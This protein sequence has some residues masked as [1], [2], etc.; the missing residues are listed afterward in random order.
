MKKIFLLLFVFL[1]SCSHNVE[2][3]T[4]YDIKNYNFEVKSGELNKINKKILLDYLINSSD[5]KYNA[6]SNVKVVLSISTR[7][8]SS[9]VSLNN[10]VML[11]N[12]LFITKYDI[13][14]DE[15]VVDNGKIVLSDD[16]EV[17]DNRFANYS[18]DSYVM[19]NFARNLS[20]KLEEK[21]K[22]IEKKFSKCAF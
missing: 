8:N 22:K 12:I 15:K 17:F 1:I 14:I 19:E 20:F 3:L 6:N 18:L 2:K 5:I 7:R 13:V 11:N 21:L 4:C 16:V 9:L 10:D